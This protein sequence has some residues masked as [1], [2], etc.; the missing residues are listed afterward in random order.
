M[1]DNLGE[2]RLR[3]VNRGVASFFLALILAARWTTNRVDVWAHGVVL[4]FG[5]A[6]DTK[7]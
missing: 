1:S 5:R 2:L 6:P 7:R 3:L 4:Y